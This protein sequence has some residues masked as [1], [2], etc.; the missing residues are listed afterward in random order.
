[1]PEVRFDHCVIRIRDWE[2]SNAFYRD[3]LGAEVTRRGDGWCY[4]IGDMQINCHGPGVTATD[5]LIE[6]GAAHLCFEWP[7]P[8]DAAKVHLDKHGI[9]VELGPVERSA[10]RG[11]G[12]SLY[13]RDPDGA[14]LELISYAGR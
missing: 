14:L 12:T 8:I 2:R 11:T 7:G 10:A 5:V 4:R 13:F 6:A 3:V 1:M 9:V